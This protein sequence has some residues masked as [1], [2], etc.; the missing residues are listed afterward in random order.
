[1]I[2][3]GFPPQLMILFSVRSYSKCFLT[4]CLHFGVLPFSGRAQDPSIFLVLDVLAGFPNR[5]PVQYTLF[6]DIYVF[7]GDPFGDVTAFDIKYPNGEPLGTPGVS[8]DGRSAF[9]YAEFPDL[10]S[11]PAG[12]YT[13]TV[14]GS[15]AGT[16]T[17]MVNVNPAYSPGPVSTQFIESTR[18]TLAAAPLQ[19][20][21]FTLKDPVSYADSTQLSFGSSSGTLF[22]E[23]RRGA[24]GSS[25]VT[26]PLNL[27]TRG[28][29]AQ[30]Q[31]TYQTAVRGPAHITLS[32]TTSYLVKFAA[33]AP[34]AASQLS[35]I[36]ARGYCG[37]GD[38]VMI[39]GFVVG[40]NTNKRVLVRAL[41]PTLT[42]LGLSSSEV[43]LDPS[44][45]VYKGANLV[46]TNDNWGSNSNVDEIT[47]TANKI[48]AG[49][50]GT[51]DAT[52][53]ALLL[54][55]TP[56]VYS[57]VASGKLGTSG[58]AL[59]E[60]YDAD[61]DTMGSRFVNISTRA[62]STTGNGVAIG[63]F[64]ISGSLPKQVMLRAVGPTLTK[65]G[66]RQAD[67]LVDPTIELH[68]ASHGNLVIA[69]NDNWG[70][71]PNAAAITSAAARIG[72]NA[73]DAADSSSSALLLTLLPGSYTFLAAG[74]NSTPGIVL[75][76]VYDA[77]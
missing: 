39:G 48:G 30:F 74:K 25:L 2:Y 10:K 3:S 6:G 36:S 59:L 38:R 4:A 76:E 77:D 57:F 11:I 47:A 34:E 56:G 12:L 41:G 54:T 32:Y 14:T 69:T 5:P 22:S 35:N 68:D 61:T 28:Q 65:L 64:V 15:L 72:A 51:G 24:G 29:S 9:R 1:M 67:V 13:V 27:L 50:I 42:S 55:L 66:I 63:G 23:D 70:D 43:L 58:I 8:S 45:E 31:A 75:V 71:N 52:S 17:Y 44:I 33:R 49:S 62:Y 21:T 53:S 19:S 60:V 73:F 7:A 46:A 37:A 20:F 26:L 18:A 16:K 40:G